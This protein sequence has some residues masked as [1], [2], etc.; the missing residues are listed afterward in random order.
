MSKGNHPLEPLLRPKSIAIIGASEKQGVISGMSLRNLLKY[1]YPGKIFPVNPSYEKLMDIPCYKSV[2]DIP[3]PVDTAV[4]VIPAKGVLPVLEDC[5]RKGVKTIT[6]V[7]SGFGEAGGGES[8]AQMQEKVKRLARES[9]VRILGPNCIGLMN[10]P[11][12]IIQRGALYLVEDMIPGPVGMVSH[13]G[14]VS[15]IMFNRAQAHGVGI[16]FVAPSGN[17]VDLEMCD[18]IDFMV[19]DPGTKVI[20]AYIEGLK[21][22]K[23]FLQVARKAAS[24]AK[25]IIAV[26][27][28][29]SREGRK[30]ALAHTGALTGSDV[31][32]DAAFRKTAVTRVADIDALH[33]AGLLFSSAPLPRGRRVGVI[34]VSGG[35]AIWVADACADMG[36]EMP[37][38]SAQ[39]RQTINERMK[40]G[41]AQNP[42]DLTGQLF[43]DPELLTTCLQMF[44]QQ[45]NLDSIL[46]VIP[47]LGSAHAKWICPPVIKAARELNKPFVVTWWSCGPDSLVAHQMFREAHVPAY[48]TPYRALAALKAYVEYAERLQPVQAELASPIAAKPSPR[49]TELVKRIHDAGRPLSLADTEVL[50]LL[51]EYDIPVV[52]QAAVSSRESAVE[53]A[54][55][56]GFQVVLKVN[57]PAIVHKTDVGCVKVGLGT[58]DQVAEAYDQI[59]HNAKAADPQAA[60]AGVVVQPMLHGVETILG[61]S[62]DPQFGPVVMFGSGGV[63]A[64]L[65]K[66]VSHRL[67]P[68]SDAE[69]AQMIREVRGF[70]LLSGFRGQP[71]ADIGALQQLLVRL[72]KAAVDLEGAISSMDLNPVVVMP[73]G[74]GAAVVD[75]RIIPSNLPR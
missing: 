60:I 68:L 40:F 39:A 3:E 2:L 18:L 26:K 58:P 34:T 69:A 29:H 43:G 32:H 41:K 45:D 72:G 15:L 30:A 74:S 64:E 48:Q 73:P 33:E 5:V 12:C 49:R 47:T 65:W 10:V 61:L 67:A 16:S 44:G 51:T 14:G 66:D 22:G 55:K 28:G 6:V 25:P 50:D 8:G 63:N 75:A 42:L 11:D 27:V 56:L 21:D 13:S 38:L 35:E 17:E 62:M 20:C 59:L 19:E 46:M 53:T 36:L 7:S 37:E 31:V 52:K 4:V 9:G 1:K 24:V 70:P 57:A 23:R 54:K 71:P